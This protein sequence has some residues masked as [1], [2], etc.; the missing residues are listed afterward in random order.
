M[1]K[2]FSFS[3]CG[4]V[5]LQS[6]ILAERAANSHFSENAQYNLISIVYSDI[7]FNIDKLH[8]VVYKF[9]VA[10]YLCKSRCQDFGATARQAA[11]SVVSPPKER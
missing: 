8:T 11:L 6:P 10:P 9:L 5:V 1:S 4:S 7:F 3:A 2:N